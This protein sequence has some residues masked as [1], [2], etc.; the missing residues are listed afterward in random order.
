[1]RTEIR[2]LS[3]SSWVSPGP[4]KP[5]P[6]FCRSRCVQPLT[7][8]VDKC[9]SC[10]NSTCNFPSNELALREKISKIKPVR[11]ITWHSRSFSKLRSCE[12]ESSAEKITKSSS[13]SFTN[14]ANSTTLPE[15]IKCLA[16][17]LLRITLR[18]LMTFSPD[19][20]ANSKNSSIPL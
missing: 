10:A 15:P 2:R 3:V 13:N 16:L 9:L 18:F 20:F 12:G 8:R 7:S 17:A 1:M 19:D 14:S 6:P 4:L 5:I 11:S